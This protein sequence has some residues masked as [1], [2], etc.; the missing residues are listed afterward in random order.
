MFNPSEQDERNYLSSVKDNIKEALKTIDLKLETYA[1]ELKENKEYLYENKAEMDRVE[2]NSVRETITQKAASGENAVAKKARL[3]KLLLSP[4]FGRVDFLQK[5]TTAEKPVY[6]GVH[7]YFDEEN[8]KN[9]IHDWRAPVAS[10]YYDFELGDA[11]YHSPSGKITGE[12]RIKRQYRIRNGNMQ[13]MLENSANIYD[14]VLQEELSKTSDEKM[15]N[16]AAT[17]QSDQN[18]VIRNEKS[19]TLIIQG[20]AGSGK[21]SIALHRIAFLLYRFKDEIR[22]KDILIVSPNK[23]FADYISNVLPELGEEKIPEIGMENIAQEALNNKIKF[24]SFAQQVSKI[25]ENKDKA[26]IERIRFKAGSDFLNRLDKYLLHIENNYFTPKDLRINRYPIPAWFF[27]ERFE[28]YHRMPIFKRFDEIVKETEDN[29]LL[30]YRQEVTP[31]ERKQIRK[32]VRGMFKVNT[33]L[34]LYKNFYEWLDIPEMFKKSVKQGYEYAD[35]FPLIYLK[36]RLEGVHSYSQVKHL[37]VDEMQDYTP[38][39]YAVLS[40]MFSC[41]KT[42]LG[43]ANQ[44]VNPY[45]SVSAEDIKKVFPEAD[46]V[47]LLKSYRSTYE[48]TQFSQK[49]LPNP[50]LIPIERRGEKPSLKLFKNPEA[51]MDDIIE[52]AEA[53]KNSEHKS[54][55]IIC[56]TQKE[57]ESLH[58]EFSERKFPVHLLTSDS[59]SYAQGILITTVHMA[60]GLEFDRVLVPFADSKNYHTE[61]D[62]NML[63]IACTRAMHIL[64]IVCTGKPSLFLPNN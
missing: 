4:Y 30:Y 27:K 59:V 18:A 17:I 8:Q 20:V 9:I 61:L 64:K 11:Y 47:R 10:L 3:H 16:I 34:A 23:V 28:T 12:V 49:I 31:E 58:N 13:F 56:K 5:S 48:I 44:S 50:Q 57:A 43:D 21:T 19:R 41:K 2:K 60:K 45:S 33:L 46:T 52:T 35:V 37:L 22:S 62:K 7:S 6:I 26:F 54:L 42:I 40:K 53:F 14:D 24:Q 29:I 32:E 1:R 51:E 25:L 39:Q 36:I 38:V 63:Y 15:K 55:G